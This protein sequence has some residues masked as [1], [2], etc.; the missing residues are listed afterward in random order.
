M[1]EHNLFIRLTAETVLAPFDVSTIFPGQARPLVV[2][3]GCGKGRLILAHARRHPDVWHLGVD[4]M[5]GRLRKAARGALRLGLTNIRLL[6]MDA[7]YAVCHLLP[8]HGVR[9]LFIA[10]PDPWPKPRHHRHRLF[11]PIFLD[12]LAKTLEPGGSV[13]VIT[14]HLPY[15][16]TICHCVAADPRFHIG[17]VWL[18]EE[19]ERTDFELEFLNERPIG[20]ITFQLSAGPR[21]GFGTLG[22]AVPA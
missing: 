6:R 8:R 2:D 12:A 22:R 21:R 19:S 18:P 3:L 13:H 11:S 17:P 1:D 15:F 10:F 16:A 9:E 7:L 5:L 14:D 20:R 4:R